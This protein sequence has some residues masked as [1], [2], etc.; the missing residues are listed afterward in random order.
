MWKGRRVMA[1]WK[2]GKKSNANKCL[3]SQA[4]NEP[5]GILHHNTAEDN[6]RNTEIG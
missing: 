6:D 5:G 3:R 4:D 1:S 2:E